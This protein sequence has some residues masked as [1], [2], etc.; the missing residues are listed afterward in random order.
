MANDYESISRRTGAE[1]KLFL[2]MD[3]QLL[4]S[5]IS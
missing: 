4:I 5:W 2:L 1:N 3:Y